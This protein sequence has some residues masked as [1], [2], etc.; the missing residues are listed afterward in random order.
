MMDLNVRLFGG[1]EVRRNAG[2]LVAFPTRKARALFA[3][4]ARHPGERLG[5]ERLAAMLWPRNAESEARGSLRQALK[6]VRRELAERGSEII[7]GEGDG[8]LLAPETAQID[9]DLFERLHATGT[10]ETFE[11]AAAL[12]R[13]DFL[14]GAN[15]ADGP[16]ANWAMVER[17]SLRE[18]ALDVLSRL[19][20]LLVDAGRTEAAIGMAL[21]LLALDPFQEHVHRRLIQLYVE[22]GRRGSALEQYR[23]CRDTLQREL[24]V[25]PEV[26][27]EQLH[28]QIRHLRP[29]VEVSAPVSESAPEAEAPSGP[30]V[31]DTFLARPAVAVLPFANL[32]GDPTQT[33]FSDGLSEDLITALAGWRRFPVVASSST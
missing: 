5:R 33:Y 7:I 23:I 32:D 19:L 9:V 15:L 13:G 22:Q 8:L 14:E 2:P 30:R 17:T 1:F 27:T 4:L 29:R 18:R 11:R 26:E 3:L 10:T 31:A 20:D 28:E 21:R 6:L 25:R 24:G 16:F 12:Y